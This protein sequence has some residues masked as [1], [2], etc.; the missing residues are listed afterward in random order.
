MYRE[1]PSFYSPCAERDVE[2]TADSNSW[3][4]FQ[5]ATFGFLLTV[6][7]I[8]CIIQKVVHDRENGQQWF[9]FTHKH[10][11]AFNEVK[12]GVQNSNNR[13]INYYKE[14]L[15]H[16]RNPQREARIEDDE[17]DLKSIY[18]RHELKLQAETDKYH[19]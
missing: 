5:G 14:N 6:A 19:V 7:C 18:A 13:E 1:Y 4:K 8:V 2:C 17:I 10:L 3:H 9:K 11:R 12:E 15:I 16:L